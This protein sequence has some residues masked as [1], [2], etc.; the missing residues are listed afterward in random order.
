MPPI[1]N[2]ELPPAPEP[3]SDDEIVAVSAAASS[4]KAAKPTVV[5]GETQ[6]EATKRKR[7]AEEA[8]L[9]PNGEGRKAK[10][11]RAKEDV[12]TLD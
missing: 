8:G 3:E 6:G 11:V 9:D 4:D 5:E 2:K 7:A 1:P 12:I 10:A